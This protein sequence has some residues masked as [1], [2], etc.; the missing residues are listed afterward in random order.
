M[1]D[2]GV[3]SGVLMLLLGQ[4]A[5]GNSCSIDALSKQVF[6]SAKQGN[7]AALLATLKVSVRAI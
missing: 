3:K 4:P 1:R 7:A 2:S 6:D 5:G